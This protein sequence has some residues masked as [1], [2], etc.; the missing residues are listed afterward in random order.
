MKSRDRRGAY[1]Q[2]TLALAA[3]VRQV[4]RAHPL[5]TRAVTATSAGDA[6]CPNRV[7]STHR[8]EPLRIRTTG[9]VI[10]SIDDDDAFDRRSDGL[11]QTIRSQ[12]AD[13]GDSASRAGTFHRCQA[14]QGVWIRRWSP[15]TRQQGAQHP[16]NL[17]DAFID[18]RLRPPHAPHSLSDRQEEAA[19]VNGV[20]PTVIAAAGPGV[21]D[22]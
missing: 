2:L 14:G 5:V 20:S 18:G 12:C 3:R 16:Y 10:V 4:L 11:G 9:A 13:R 15:T 1:P 6:D 17:W 19:D 22:L 21:R 7:E 8:S